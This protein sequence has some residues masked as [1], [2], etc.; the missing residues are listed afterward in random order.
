MALHG[1]KSNGFCTASIGLKTAA[2]GR[3]RGME[4]RERSRSRRA[5]LYHAIWTTAQTRQAIHPNFTEVEIC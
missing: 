3:P 5:C 2:G 4:T 1:E